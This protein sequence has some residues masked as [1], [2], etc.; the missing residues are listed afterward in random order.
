VRRVAGPASQWRRDIDVL[1]PVGNPYGGRHGGGLELL[2]D[3]GDDTGLVGNPTVLEAISG[4]HADDARNCEQLQAIALEDI[5]D[6]L[7]SS[8]ILR[9][10]RRGADPG[11]CLRAQK[12]SARLI[13]SQTDTG[14]DQRPKLGLCG[15]SGLVQAR[16]IRWQGICREDFDRKPTDG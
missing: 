4:P 7:K 13:S 1:D 15:F 12:V 9:L 14:A 2:I 10:D 11:Q 6:D 16:F 8:L 5:A 3:D